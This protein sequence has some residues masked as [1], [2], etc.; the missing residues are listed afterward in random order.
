MLTTEIGQVA[1]ES[2]K[3][4]TEEITRDYANP[5]SVT[6]A[7][8]IE[9]RICRIIEDSVS[10]GPALYVKDDGNGMDHAALVRML[11]MGHARDEHNK[12][13][14]GKYGVGF[15]SGSMRIGKT[16]V[17]ITRQEGSGSVGMLSQVWGTGQL[18][19]PVNV[20]VPKEIW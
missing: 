4:I 1:W 20:L 9:M 6:P 17:V 19:C 16:A 11:S 3:K 8:T 15:K 7:S 10:K 14:L 2:E 5:D 18:W 13:K 12:N